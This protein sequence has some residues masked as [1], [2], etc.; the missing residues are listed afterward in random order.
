MR[1][2]EKSRN[3]PI[4]RDSRLQV[5]SEAQEAIHSLALGL[6]TFGPLNLGEYFLVQGE[7]L[8]AFDGCSHSY[9]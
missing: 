4:Q 7:S 2:I 5:Q 6:R 8:G 9:K 3:L 1:I